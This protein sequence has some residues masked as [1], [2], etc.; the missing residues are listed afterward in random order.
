M[1]DLP[2]I[3]LRPCRADDLDTVK[4]ITAEAF[5]GV[6]IDQA[7]EQRIGTVGG[8]D[9]HWH[10]MRH[11]DHDFSDGLIMVAEDDAE[12]IVGYI[13]MRI[14]REAKTGSIPNLA[15][16]ASFRGR[17]I[18][19]LLLE[20]ALKTFHAEGLELARIETLSQNP[21]GLRLYTDLGFEVVA[22]QLHFAMKLQNPS[23]HGDG[24]ET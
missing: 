12:K 10:K 23:T 5:T 20:K 8:R 7:I 1:P 19:R 24:S 2:P 11:L 9:W 14:D 16:S 21:I 4:T 6:S 15:V 18:G 13:T 3:I 22:S 17:G